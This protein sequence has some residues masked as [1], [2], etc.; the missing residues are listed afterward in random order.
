MAVLRE[1]PLNVT[2][3]VAIGSAK[4]M[5]TIIITMTKV[6]KEIMIIIMIIMID[7]LVSPLHGDEYDELLY[8]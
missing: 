6:L 3:N 2:V 8:S 7:D 5:N 1:M 4:A